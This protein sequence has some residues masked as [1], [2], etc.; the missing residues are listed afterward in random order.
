MG[1]MSTMLQE[2]EIKVI[3][4]GPGVI[5]SIEGV[6]SDEM[7]AI[8]AEVSTTMS[9]EIYED[10]LLLFQELKQDIR[11]MGYVVLMVSNTGKD[12][13]MKKFWKMFGF[14]VFTH[15]DGMIGFMMLED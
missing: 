7:V 12:L 9:K 6:G 4:D 11:E 2:Q 1:G 13:K 8:H 10:W 3:Y 15:G 14:D 5:V